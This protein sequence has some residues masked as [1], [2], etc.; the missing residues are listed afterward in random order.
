MRFEPTGIPGLF[1]VHLDWRTDERG[2]FL[3]L[4]DADAFA[5]QGLPAAFPQTSLSATRQ[6]GTIRGLHVQRPPFAEVKL[7]RCL[8][9]ALFDVVLDLRPGSPTRLQWRPFTLREGDDL[10]LAIPQGCAHGFQTLVDGTEVLYQISAPHAPDHADGVRFDDPAL[11]IQWPLP[12][13]VVSTRD[14]GW[15]V[16]A[17][18]PSCGP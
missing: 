9:G 12:V 18:L 13:T 2:G 7:V 3:R 15:P 16:L 10:L 6:A 17:G 8:R 4:F 14:R 1:L 5:A 11:A